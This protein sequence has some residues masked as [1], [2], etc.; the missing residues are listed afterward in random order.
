M[1][2]RALP[3]ELIAFLNVAIHSI[4]QLEA[5]LLLSSDSNKQWTAK[6]IAV[7][8]S[9]NPSATEKW[10]KEFVNLGLAEEIKDTPGTY[11]YKPLDKRREDAVALLALEYRL[12]PLK[13]IDVVV[14]KTTHKMMS[15]MEAFKIKKEDSENDS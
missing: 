7:A 3:T 4:R 15:F 1:E 9:A 13:V 10:L 12:R 8:L 11:F 6:T 2:L 14:N 5:L